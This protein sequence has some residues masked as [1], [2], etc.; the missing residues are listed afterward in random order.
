MSLLVI[1]EILGLVVKSFTADDKYSLLNRDNLLQPIESKLSK[2]NLFYFFDAILKSRPNF[3]YFKKKDD[4][5]S[6][7]ISEMT[8]CEK[9]S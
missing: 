7:C 3:E 2:K 5:H 9:R 1:C 4:T 8:D 6:W